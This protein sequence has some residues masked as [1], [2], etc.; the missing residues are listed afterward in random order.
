MRETYPLTD[1][2]LEVLSGHVTEIASEWEKSTGY[3]YQILS[4]LE[5]DPFGKFRGIYAAAV[6][7]G[8]DVTPWDAALCEIK[9]RYARERRSDSECIA[10]KIIRDADCTKQI[11]QA[12]QDG[13]LDEKE[14]RSIR[15]AIQKER[16]SLDEIEAMVAEKP[17]AM[18]SEVARFKANGGR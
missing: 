3:L 18:P 10:D 6:R 2:T 14:Q 5:P 11:V 7:A 9:T 4:S 15:R 17:L 13:K 8:A 12:L 16:D 1:P